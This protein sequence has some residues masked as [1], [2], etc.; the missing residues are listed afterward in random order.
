MG[1]RFDF[2]MGDFTVKT[3]KTRDGYGLSGDIPPR[4]AEVAARL[5]IASQFHGAKLK[6]SAELVEVEPGDI[7]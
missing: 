6:I 2:E 7:N 3:Y 5:L 1:E 4:L